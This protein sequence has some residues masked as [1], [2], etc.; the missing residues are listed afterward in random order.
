MKKLSKSQIADIDKLVDDCRAAESVLRG[1][2][3]LYHE[4]CFALAE[5]YHEHGIDARAY[6][7]ERSEK[8]QGSEAGE[9]YADWVDALEEFNID[10]TDI[11]YLD[12]D[13]LPATGP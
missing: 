7:D 11:N 10:D 12:L 4:R 9:A 6:F 3:E 1:A 5:R 8:W 13:D 2:V